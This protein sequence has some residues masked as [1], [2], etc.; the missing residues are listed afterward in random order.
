MTVF[1]TIVTEL[2]PTPLGL[3]PARW[4]IEH[5]CTTCRH[6][7]AA[8]DLLAHAQTHHHDTL[9]HLGGAID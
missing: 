7:V 3:L 2:P 8:T 6:H 4:T 1:R 5:W 9:H